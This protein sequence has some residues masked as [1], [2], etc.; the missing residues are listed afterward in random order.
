MYKRIT[1]RDIKSS[2]NIENFANELLNPIEKLLENEGEAT[3][4]ELVLTPQRTHHHHRA[5]ILVKTP[6]YELFADSVEPDMYLAIR[7]VI[8]KMH[9]NI[10]N[11]KK[12]LIDERKK[13][14][15]HR[16]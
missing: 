3:Y 13:G 7:N 5:E 12:E 10:S 9:L 14:L 16:E 2:E 1:L 6:R 15:N 8:D 4:L 11:K